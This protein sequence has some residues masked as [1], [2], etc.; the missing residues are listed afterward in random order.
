MRNPTWAEVL[1]AIGKE[2]LPDDFLSKAD[3]DRSMPQDR[4][5]ILNFSDDD[6]EPLTDEDRK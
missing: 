4:S 5:D 6:S 3:R 2:P 1:E